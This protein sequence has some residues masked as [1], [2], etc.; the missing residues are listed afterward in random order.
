LAQVTKLRQQ[1]LDDVK[2]GDELF[3][4]KQF[5][6]AAERYRDAVSINPRLADARLGLAKTLEKMPKPTAAMLNESAQQYRNYVVLKTDLPEKDKQKLLTQ[7]DKLSNRA[8]K[9]AQM[10]SDH[11]NLQRGRVYPRP[12][13]QGSGRRAGDL[14]S[15]CTGGVHL[16]PQVSGI[17]DRGRG[18]ARP[19]IG[20]WTVL[21]KQACRGRPRSTRWRVASAVA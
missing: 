7:A 6:G 5:D 14:T 1:A 4:K 13:C 10:R 9:L 21:S 19:K 16:L 8:A 2:V 18:C 15:V 12:R 3:K 17:L 11:E 20:S